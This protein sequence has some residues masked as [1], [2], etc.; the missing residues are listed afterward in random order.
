MCD[1]C[2]RKDNNY[3]IVN[4]SVSKQVCSSCFNKT[5]NYLRSKKHYNFYESKSKKIIVW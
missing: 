5:L 1:L 2:S 3:R 4:K